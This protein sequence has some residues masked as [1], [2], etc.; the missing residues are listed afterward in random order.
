MSSVPLI[1][2]SIVLVALVA[3]LIFYYGDSRKLPWYVLLIS[4]VAFFFPFSIG[5]LLPIDLTS[6]L[7]RQCLS[8]G[9]ESCREPFAFVSEGFL[10]IA[11]RTIYWISFFLTWLVIPVTLSFVDR[12]DFNTVTRLVRSLKDQLLHFGAMLALG[13]F[14]LIYL[15]VTQTLT[16]VANGG[17][18]LAFVMAMANT[19]GLLL[20]IIFMG[21]GLVDVPRR[22]W[23]SANTERELKQLYIRAPRMKDELEDAEA[24]L[25]DIASELLQVSNKLDDGDPLRLHLDRL[26][27]NF[28]MAMD[29]RIH[30]DVA[31]EQIPGEINEKYLANLNRRMRRALNIRDRCQALWTG[32][33]NRAYHLQDI[34]SSAENPEKVFVSSIRSDF[35]RWR[36]ALE[37]WWYIRLH[38]LFKRGLAC[39]CGF[40][41]VALIWSEMTFNLNPALSIVRLFINSAN[42]AYGIVEILSIIFVAYMCITSYTALFKIRVFNYYL[43]VPNHHTDAVSLLFCGAY[44]CRLTAPLCYNY[45]NMINEKAQQTVFW[46]FMGAIDLVPFLGST[47]NNWMPLIVLLPATVRLFNIHSK[48]LSFFDTGYLKSYE[49][50]DEATASEAGISPEEQEGRRLVA[51]AQHRLTG[52]GNA[53]DT[54]QTRRSRG[55][56]RNFEIYGSKYGLRRNQ[57]ASRSGIAIENSAHCNDAASLRSELLSSRT[58]AQHQSPTFTPAGNSNPSSRSTSPWRRYSGDEEDLEDETEQGGF[59][60][61]NAKNRLDS[62]KSAFSNLWQRVRRDPSSE[63]LSSL[64]STVRRGSRENRSSRRHGRDNRAAPDS[65]FDDV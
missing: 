51:E 5:L 25:I 8:S 18:L 2:G 34:L 20:V 23:M 19:W 64:S 58:G 38:P 22:L 53:A 46:K 31:R 13:I 33:L 37:W 44:L 3:S 15:V 60:R 4:F 39:F 9:M 28:P 21:Y 59:L 62:A 47:L 6:S 65:I 14:G 11:W 36:S 10:L 56:E 26:M 45:L 35:S 1:V 41:S 29:S 12:G 42:F 16:K 40:L 17:S 55:S 61:R 49:D 52:A 63:N 32:L 43:M 48:V 57:R 7:Y 30:D 50:D 27:S 24:E 54:G